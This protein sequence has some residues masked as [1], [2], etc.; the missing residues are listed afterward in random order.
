MLRLVQRCRLAWGDCTPA[1]GLYIV[2][3]SLLYYTHTLYYTDILLYCTVLTMYCT[4]TYSGSVDL[5]AP[6]SMKEL[7]ASDP[8][9][10]CIPPN[11]VFKYISKG[12]GVL[13]LEWFLAIL[14]NEVIWMGAKGH[15]GPATSKC[16]NDLFLRDSSPSSVVLHPPIS[17]WNPYPPF[18]SRS[19]VSLHLL[20]R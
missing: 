12:H 18:I 3:C 10:H 14:G 20:F 4:V 17:R 16:Y 19:R 8:G 9:R 6:S 5:E 7:G 1:A 15:F 2:H 11:C 13:A